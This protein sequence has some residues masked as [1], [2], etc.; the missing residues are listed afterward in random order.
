MTVQWSEDPIEV[1]PS[2]NY[3]T[4]FVTLRG[5]QDLGGGEDRD[6]TVRIEWG[7]TETPNQ[8]ALLANVNTLWDSMVTAGYTITQAHAAGVDV[9]QM[10]DH[11]AKPPSA[12]RRVGGF[13][14]FRAGGRTQAYPDNGVRSRSAR[15]LTE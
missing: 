3:Y 15:S 9:L 1:I 6:I 12:S 10:P 4:S 11:K 14:D 8:S 13:S 5:A 7:G 2:L